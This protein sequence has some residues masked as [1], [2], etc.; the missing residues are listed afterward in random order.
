MARRR[1]SLAQRLLHLLPALLLLTLPLAAAGQAPAQKPAPHP[2]DQILQAETYQ[3]PPKA[4]ADAVLAPRYLNISL[5]EASRDKKWFVNEI[6]DGPVPMK[7]FSKPFHELGGVFVDFRASRAR[8]L[9]IRTNV[10]IQIIS[11]AD[12]SKRPVEVP[13]GARVSSAT[14]SPD[15]SAVAFFVHAD[16]ATHIWVA[17]ASD[18]KSRQVTKT[19]VLAT[20]VTSFQFTEDG[21]QIAAVLVPDGRAPMPQAPAAP[22]GPTAKIADSG[23]KNRLRTFAS[24]MTT[25]YEQAL[26][27]WHATGQLVMIDVKTGA[28]KKVGKPDMIRSID[29]SNDGGYLRVMRMVKPFSYDVP[30]SNFGTVE[31]IWDG[32]GKALATVTERPLDLGVQDDTAPDP[33]AG[34]SSPQSAH[35]SNDGSSPRIRNKPSSNQ[36]TCVAAIS[37]SA[38]AASVSSARSNRP[39]W[40]S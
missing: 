25:P 38:R 31:E 24:L 29:P 23:N 15:G 18:G 40:A 3:A 13:L 17:S 20:L 28:A 14:W 34:T 19:P 1:G 36:S 9:T 8:S 6:G 4:L 39:G 30:V 2:A 21:K 26:L 12:G 5:S 11:A 33:A 27:E 16:D 22:P 32:T 10:G 7:T 37:P 35:C